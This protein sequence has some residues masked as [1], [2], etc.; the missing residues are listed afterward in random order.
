MSDADRIVYDDG[1]DR[2]APSLSWKAA[3]LA[4]VLLGSGVG[5]GVMSIRPLESA[6]ALA[7]VEPAPARIVAATSGTRTQRGYLAVLVAG[8][9]VEVTAPA[10]GRLV[11]LP[12]DVGQE[13]ERGQ[14]LAR[15]DDPQARQELPIAQAALASARADVHKQRLLLA[16]AEERL[17]RRTSEQR[18][19]LISR[20]EFDDA[21][22]GRDAAAADLGLAESRVVEQEARVQQ[23]HERLAQQSL[24]SPIKGRVTARHFDVGARVQNGAAIVR[25]IG[26]GDLLLRF[27]VPEA[28]R[29]VLEHARTI[30][31]VRAG[32]ADDA[33][34]TAGS[35][36][37]VAPEVDAAARM[38]YVTAK[39]DSDK[40]PRRDE[41][42]G[43]NV[44][45]IGR[46][47]LLDESAESGKKD[48]DRPF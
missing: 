33:G 39:L 11:A 43:M 28:E 30:R 7:P 46:V 6:A 17:V 24:S 25:V 38:I 32:E 13:V 16:A 9:S 41:N 3:I 1:G 18:L 19:G 45:M 37:H 26:A 23:G 44:G 48:F 8:E 21:R 40:R 36:V 35:I 29:A 2:D 31:F 22:A 20:E 10:P 27:A 12:V 5:I 34:G 15:L 4:V 47:W 42:V 14:L